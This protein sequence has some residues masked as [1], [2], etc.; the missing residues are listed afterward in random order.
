MSRL[1]TTRQLVHVS[2][3]SAERASHTPAVSVPRERLDPAWDDPGRVLRGPIA[4]PRRGAFLPGRAAVAAHGNEVDARVELVAGGGRGDDAHGD[5]TVWPDSEVAGA[6]LTVNSG[7]RAPGGAAVAANRV[8]H[9]AAVI[10]NHMRRAIRRHGDPGAIIE[11]Q[12]RQSGPTPR[13]AGVAASADGD[14][15]ALERCAVEQHADEVERAVPADGEVDVGVADSA[16][17]FAP[18]VDARPCRASIAAL[19]QRR[20]RLAVSGHEQAA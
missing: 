11:A 5:L 14:L 20:S 8:R 19:P 17:G 9:P 18:D 16:L 4:P 12:L 3:W 1:A 6:A 13:R 10:P 15:P 2:A 7:A